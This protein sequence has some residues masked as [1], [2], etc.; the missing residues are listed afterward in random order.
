MI[1]AGCRCKQCTWSGGTAINIL[2]GSGCFGYFYESI[3]MKTVSSSDFIVHLSLDK[4]FIIIIISYG[5][6][7]FA[8]TFDRSR[9]QVS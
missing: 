6:Q 5:V 3:L 1:H 2:A 9:L 8:Q 4:T 7:D